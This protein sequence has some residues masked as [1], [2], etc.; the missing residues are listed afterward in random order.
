MHIRRTAVL[1][2]VCFFLASLGAFC[3]SREN[4]NQTPK[5]LTAL[6][7]IKPGLKVEARAIQALADKILEDNAY[8]AKSF[9]E[10]DF[11]GTAKRLGERG[12]SLV[13]HNYEKLWGKHSAEFWQ[14]SWKDGA[15][16]EVVTVGIM[17]TDII[18]RQTVQKCLPDQSKMLF[19]TYDLA[20][21][22]VQEFHVKEPAPAAGNRTMLCGLVYRHQ[23]TCI[24]E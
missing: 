20:A 2:V 4:P 7:K 18:G 3:Q 19:V 14:A 13:A 12:A 21:T 11:I 9:G 5:A 16:L 15:S 6:V 10:K 22:V 24:W 1:V 8:L 23:D 17:V